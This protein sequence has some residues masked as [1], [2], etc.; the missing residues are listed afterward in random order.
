MKVN[1]Q[2][3]AQVDVMMQKAREEMAAAVPCEK[4]RE[5]A[6]LLCLAKTTFEES[7][8]AAL[9]AALKAPQVAADVRRIVRAHEAANDG[10]LDAAAALTLAYGLNPVAV[11]DA[12]DKLLAISSAS[13]D[14]IRDYLRDTGADAQGAQAGDGDTI[15]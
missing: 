14:R 13:S 9:Q 15:P 2:Q 7:A 12:A 3:R 6:N 10:L 8:K 1:K 4:T 11:A 5:V